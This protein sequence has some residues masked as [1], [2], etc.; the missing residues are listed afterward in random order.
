MKRL[1][2]LSIFG[3]LA[4]AALLRLLRWRVPLGKIGFTRIGPLT[5]MLGLLPAEDPIQP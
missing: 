4:A 1:L 2:Y 3:L 5:L